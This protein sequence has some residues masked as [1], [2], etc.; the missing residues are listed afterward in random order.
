MKKLE[1]VPGAGIRKDDSWRALLR[2]HRDRVIATG[3]QPAAAYVLLN[4]LRC[5]SF[6]ELEE[7]ESEIGKILA[8]PR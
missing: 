2:E 3:G 8:L 7:L 6:P 1:S 5:R 4:E